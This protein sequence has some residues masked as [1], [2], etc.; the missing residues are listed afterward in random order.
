MYVYLMTQICVRFE[1]SQI[2]KNRVCFMTNLIN[3]DV[4]KRDFHI[5]DVREE[6]PSP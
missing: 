4:K 3:F 6:D 5:L 2:F 1:F